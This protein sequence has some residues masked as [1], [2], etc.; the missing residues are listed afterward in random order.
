[1]TNRYKVVIKVNAES[2]RHAE[3]SVTDAIWQGIEKGH[4]NL[5]SYKIKVK[6]IDGDS[7]DK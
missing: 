2:L 3:D 7:G 6:E 1:M 5:E 4:S